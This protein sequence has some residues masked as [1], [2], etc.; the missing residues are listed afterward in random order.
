MDVVFLLLVFFIYAMMSMA[1]HRAMPL[2]LPRS[3]T[4]APERG[5]GM[6]LTVMADGSLYLDREPVVLENLAGILTE[7]MEE[8]TAAGETDGEAIRV[9]G[10][11]ELSYQTLYRVLD[12][13]RIAGVQK[14]SL[15]ADPRSP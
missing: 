10:A 12:Q 11:A 8:K 6:A 3:S 9:F 2:N 15:Q 4:A 13:I 1:V 7:R 5:P 14:I